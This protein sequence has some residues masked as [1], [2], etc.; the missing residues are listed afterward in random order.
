MVEPL[1]TSTVTSQFKVQKANS[2]SSPT[3]VTRL[4]LYE[5]VRVWW[6][7]RWNRTWWAWTKLWLLDT[8]LSR[9][10]IWPVLSYQWRMKMS[11]LPQQAT[12]WRLCKVR[13]QVSTLQ[14]RVVRLV[15]VSTCFCVDH[16]LF[17]ATTSPCSLLTDSLVA[18]MPSIRMISRAL[19]CWKTLLQRQSMVLLVLMV[20]LLSRLSVALQVRLKLTSMLISDGVVHLNT[21]MVWQVT[22]GLITIVRHINIRM[23]VILR[24][25]VPWWEAIKIIS[26]PIMKANGLIGLTRSLV[27]RQRRRNMHSRLLV[28][29]KR[30]RYLPLQCTR[31]IKVCW[32]ANN[33]TNMHYALILTKK[34]SLGQ[35]WALLLTWTIPYM[36]EVTIRHIHVHWQH[37]LWVMSMTIMVECVMSTL[38][39]SI[40]R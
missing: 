40:V 32:R 36:I 25:S 2:F 28:E 1:L 3:P 29:L 17:M 33:V 18:M 6:V 15:L 16:A 39:I 5:L 26:M 20:L 21:K 31:R 24:I 11:R 34:S 37:S 10:V 22:S 9:N 23:A 7:S 27:V 12:W 4:R 14:K 19:T 38:P 35:R 13:L 30:Q 8:E